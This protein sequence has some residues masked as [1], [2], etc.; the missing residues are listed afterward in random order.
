MSRYPKRVSDFHPTTQKIFLVACREVHPNSGECVC[1]SC[2][3][4]R[5]RIERLL[6][7]YRAMD[8]IAEQS[9]SG[10]TAAAAGEKPS[11]DL[12]EGEPYGP[13]WHTAVHNHAPEEGPGLLCRE[14]R[15]PDGS[16]RGECMEGGEGS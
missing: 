4:A 16:L 7:A 11:R 2:I 14:R 6:E 1:S 10:G 13:N 3:S 12:D 8:H 5:I 9:Q 15:M